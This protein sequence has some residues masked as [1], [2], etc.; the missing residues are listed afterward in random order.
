MINPPLAVTSCVTL[1]LVVTEQ[2]TIKG[3]LHTTEGEAGSPKEESLTGRRDFI[4][5]SG[6]APSD[7]PDHCLHPNRASLSCTTNCTQ[8]FF[9][10]SENK[11]V[12]FLSYCLFCCIYYNLFLTY[13]SSGFSFQKNNKQNHS[14][15]IF[16]PVVLFISIWLLLIYKAIRFIVNF[17]DHGCI[18]LKY[19]ISSTWVFEYSENA[20]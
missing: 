5:G 11:I 17:P 20:K 3:P 18:D 9:I 10:Y 13:F 8:L 4:L 19:F 7:G 6:S 12:F 1:N 15:A 2:R 14:A 16:T